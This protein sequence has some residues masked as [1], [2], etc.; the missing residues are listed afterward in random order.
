MNMFST[1]IGAVAML[2][3]VAAG[4]IATSLLKLTGTIETVVRMVLVALGM[5]V[6]AGVQ[7]WWT[8]RQQKGAAAA[9][10]GRG[11]AAAGGAP[12][13][14]LEPLFR[15]AEARLAASSLGKDAR[16]GTLPVLLLL[17][18]S[19]SAKT[20]T[21]LACGAEPELLAGHVM[22][23]GYVVPTRSVNL[24]FTRAAV[25]L[26][27]GGQ[28]LDD[29]GRW[30]AV[31]RRLQ[32]P[33]M[34]SMFRQKKVAPRSAIVFFDIE[35]VM[36]PGGREAAINTARRLNARLGE[37]CRA[38]GIQ[39][40]VYCLFTRCDRVPFFTDF[41]GNMSDAEA[42]QVVGST[43]PMAF[44]A[45]VG[46][47]AEDETRRLTAAYEQ[48]F[49][50]LT[51]HRTIQLGREHDGSKLGNIY[52]FP[53][54]FRKLRQ[55]LVEFLVELCRPSQLQTSPFLRGFYFSGVRP[56]ETREVSRAMRQQDS[57]LFGPNAKPVVQ[58][59]GRTRR[60]P[61]W[62]FLQR[63]FN[64][65]I[66]SDHVAFQTSAKSSGPA[67]ARR[68]LFAAAAGVSLLFGTAWTVSY[69]GNRSLLK[70]VSSAVAGL[71]VATP[72]ADG[73]A[74]RDSL[75]RIETL[76]QSL[77]LLTRYSRE[78]APWSLRW[79]LYAGNDLLPTTRNLYFSRY[80]QLMFGAVQESLL[81][82]LRS[83]P[84]SPG[85]NDVYG[86]TY[87]TLKAYLITT[88]H[89]DKST[90]MFLSPL[91][92]DRWMA[93]KQVDEE[94]RSL[95]RRQFDFYSEELKHGN[96]YS[97]EN[98]TLAIERARRFLGQF[99]ASERIYRFIL[100]EANRKNPPLNFN[101][102]FAGSAQIILNGNDV[103]GAF[104]R[105]G[106]VFVEDAIKN[107]ER[108]FAGEEWV[109]GPQASA[110]LDRSKVE[111]ELL[112]RYRTDLIGNWR[113][114][115]KS[116]T[117]LRY[118]SVDDAAK[119]LLQ[120][121]GTQSYL[122]ALFCLASVNTAAASQEEV[123]QT[124]QPVQFVTPPAC[125]DRY[126]APSNQPYMN[127]LIS[128]QAA[129]EQVSRARD[130]ND[131]SV[132]Q[133]LQE[134]ARA[135]MAARQVAQNFQI[136]KDGHVEQ[137]VQKLMEDPI[138]HV[139]SL[140]GRLGPAQLNG[141]AKRFCGDFQALVNKYPFNTSSKIDAS[142]EE[143]NMIFKPGSGAL[144]VFY[145][146]NLKNALVKQGGQW[147]PAP[148][149][150]P[151]RLTAQYLRFFNRSAAFSD[152]LYRGGT[153]QDPHLAYSLRALPS[154][155]V[156]S[157]TLRIDGQQL[158][159]SGSGGGQ[160]Q[161]Q[162]PGQSVREA[163]LTG[164]LGGPE[165]GFLSY[166]GLWAVFRFFGDA[167]RWQAAGAGYNFEW[168]PRQGQSA[169]PMTLASG[170]PLTVRYFLDMGSTAPIFQKNYLSGFNC[171]SQAAQ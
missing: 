5:G 148:G 9:G 87:D 145:D 171:V 79:G 154:E 93:R 28:M 167:D 69:F 72:A 144:W 139:E 73:L 68:A 24:W 136:D 41:V 111:P 128:L 112:A 82:H 157:L 4:W 120:L 153:A 113:E 1:I 132:N 122:L 102:Q 7:L 57:S 129:V 150:G 131:P 13:E 74:S 86:T 10:A 84:S 90:R 33:A 116:S 36:Q 156:Q 99:A 88:S 169:Q 25:A 19:G 104:T 18:E 115:L 43:V 77:E 109:L 97:R 20:S 121:S 141:E 64:E 23:D 58:E 101:K 123:K 98:D 85:P 26:E 48:L 22:Q 50:G 166:E 155:G 15:D 65:V 165:F 29:Q 127:G 17:G 170:R 21:L 35:K 55:P 70:D 158:K 146:R 34:S 78:G 100:A 108:F 76:R 107:Y 92:E 105:Q 80:K 151:I 46:V 119:K 71:G 8:K 117:V 56:V 110:A 83:L 147:V 152:A 27:P 114:Y 133:T 37:V 32:P 96:P 103:Q 161:F 81:S 118:A 143:I 168:V 2:L 40:P 16:L 14:D 39:L 52:E 51:A 66:L 162:W 31:L 61:Q 125:P 38:L 130:P 164:S 60:I 95:A 134:A 126:I 63:L 149:G 53:R 54:E 6:F 135:K 160:A 44:D 89:P 11:A 142:L 42:H 75:G 47:Y 45:R 49:L 67:P 137:M 30:A 159:S 140:L 3:F 124:F 163:K 91:L 106:A 62:V 12:S 94:R 59:S 138:T